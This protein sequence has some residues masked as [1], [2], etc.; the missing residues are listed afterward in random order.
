MVNL[1]V[2]TI[3]IVGDENDYIEMQKKTEQWSILMEIYLH[4]TKAY[5]LA[6]KVYSNDIA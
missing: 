2:T 1:V 3:F 5:T 6:W 4:L